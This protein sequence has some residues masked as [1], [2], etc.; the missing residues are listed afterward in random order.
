[1]KLNINTTDE[2]VMEYF[3]ELPSDLKWSILNNFTATEIINSIENHLKGKDADYWGWDTS[4]WRW[5]SRIRKKIAEIRGIYKELRKDHESK[6]RSLEHSK[7]HY[8]K[9]YD[10]YYKVYHA[11]YDLFLN[12]KKQVG[13][14]EK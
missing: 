2:D 4:G 1:M 9:Y 10:W 12:V 8:K 5:G 6:V 11:E 13:D 14:V 7:K 3:A